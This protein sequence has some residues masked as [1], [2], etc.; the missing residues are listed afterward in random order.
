MH[1]LLVVSFVVALLVA[2]G[3]SQENPNT[4]CSGDGLDWYTSVVGET[5]CESL[6]LNGA[7]LS[8]LIFERFHLPKAQTVTVCN[9]ECK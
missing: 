1:V 8:I 7:K 9:D 4:V 2:P 5:P 3:R 6:T